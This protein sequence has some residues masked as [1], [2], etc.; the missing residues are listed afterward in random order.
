M[1]PPEEGQHDA[2]DADAAEVAAAENASDRLPDAA[3][4]RADAGDATVFVPTVP[5]EPPFYKSGTR[6]RA[7]LAVPE[8]GPPLFLGWFDTELNES[9]SFLRTSDGALRCVPETRGSPP[10]G[11]V[12]PDGSVQPPAPWYYQDSACEQPLSVLVQ[13]YERCA[14]LSSYRRYGDPEGE[15][16]FRV[17]P[18][19][20]S[21]VF[22]LRDVGC[23]PIHLDASAGGNQLSSNPPFPWTF[24][25]EELA[26]ARFV[27]GTQR[28]L[29]GGRVRRLIVEAEDGTIATTGSWDATLMEACDWERYQDE[30]VCRPRSSEQN[31]S[32][33]T[34]P[35]L[36]GTGRLRLTTLRG[37]EGHLL[38]V[39]GEYQDLLQG[40]CVPKQT[41][42]GM[43]CVPPSFGSGSSDYSACPKLAAPDDVSKVVR[44]DVVTE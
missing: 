11:I 17:R 31:A 6:L 19:G 28:T 21:D 32:A 13:R 38:A 40:A 41:T 30:F 1:V 5:D 16:V 23:A 20:P 26:P 22:A 39:T 8:S 27:A 15:R 18:A 7:R 37:P 24:V 25:V 34:L 3:A 44:F 36:E 43:F 42:G 10:F 4:E 33:A 35:Q 9:C 29:P 12:A 2:S 14:S